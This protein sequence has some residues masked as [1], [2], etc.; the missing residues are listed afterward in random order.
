MRGLGRILF[1]ASFA[2]L[3]ALLVAVDDFALAW[4]PLLKGIVRHDALVTLAGAILLAGGLGLLVPRTA[5]PSALLL[6]AAL[7]L[8]ELVLQVPVVVA[9]P[10][11]ELAWYSVS[12]NLTFV[13]GAWTIFSL[14]P[15]DGGL[16]GN[17]RLGQVL[18][19][20]AMPAIGLSHMFYV[21]LTAP[22]I[23]GWLPFHV[24]LAYVTGAAHIAAGAGILLGVLPR[25]AA[26]LE[27]VMVSLFTLL[28]WVPAV[29]A[30]PA[31]R[32]N[33]AEICTSAAVTGAAWAVAESL[34]GTPWGRLP[35]LR[36]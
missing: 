9:H 4:P 26:T 17:V 27:A 1:A 36:H 14:L 7:S 12:E 3:G 21:N 18:F 23:P 22:L 33:W 16:A 6:T 15:R 20:L 28:V 19:A 29:I 35:S 24:P 32:A 31:S 2:A 34:R 30:A 13:A 11:F 25:L 8:R 10:L 5:R